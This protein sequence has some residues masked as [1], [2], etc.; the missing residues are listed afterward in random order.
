MSPY[1]TSAAEILIKHLGLTPRAAADVQDLYSRP[2]T[3]SEAAMAS[4]LPR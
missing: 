4:A 2:A 1:S 3:A